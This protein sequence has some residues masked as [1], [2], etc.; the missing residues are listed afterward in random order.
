MNYMKNIIFFCVGVL[1]AASASAGE[2]LPAKETNAEA[3]DAKAMQ[4][5]WRPL[6]AALAGV[7]FPPPVVKGITLKITGDKYDVTVE[8]APQPDKGTVRLDATTTPKRLICAGVEGPNQ[9]KTLLAIY[10]FK[11]ADTLRICYDLAGAKHPAEFSSTEGTR[12]FLVTY[13]RQKE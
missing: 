7:P 5:V 1:V 12:L 2:N 10:E 13:K 8:G 6:E 11:D 4:G 9:G 3:A